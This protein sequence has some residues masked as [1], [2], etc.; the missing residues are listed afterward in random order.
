[1]TQVC[2]L[3]VFGETISD[4][5][6]TLGKEVFSQELLSLI[7]RELGKEPPEPYVE[8]WVAHLGRTPFVLLLHVLLDF[9]H[10]YRLLCLT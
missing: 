10:Y 2:Q 3:V 9:P 4:I 6:E 1:M 5:F 8:I 7:Q